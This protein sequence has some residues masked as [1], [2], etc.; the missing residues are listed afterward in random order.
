MNSGKTQL[1]LSR[2]ATAVFAACSPVL[3]S[4]SCRK[5]SRQNCS[6]QPLPLPSVV[7]L[8]SV[9]QILNCSS[10]FVSPPTPDAAAAFI[11]IMTSPPM[12]SSLPRATPPPSCVNPAPPPPSPLPHEAR[13]PSCPPPPCRHVIRAIHGIL[14]IAF[15]H[16]ALPVHLRPS[17]PHCRRRG[18][19]K[20]RSVPLICKC[21]EVDN[22]VDFV[23]H[24][25]TWIL[26][27]SPAPPSLCPCRCVNV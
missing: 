21:F 11:W 9:S 22:L 20:V 5:E 18:P 25:V 17:R 4:S 23:T 7:S 6:G 26:R 16:P 1:R 14:A 10:S 27:S 13:S 24:H 8:L 19:G 15:A 3:G 2:L 12:P